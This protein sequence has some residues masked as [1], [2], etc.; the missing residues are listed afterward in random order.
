MWLRN[1]VFLGLLL[2]G[3][4]SLAA[5]LFPTPT[6]PRV[7]HFNS[8]EQQP[9]DFRSVVERVDAS[10]Q[11]QWEELKLQPAERT[12]DL[13]VAQRLSL[14]LMGTIPS[15]QEI[16]E[17]EKRPAEERIEWW[18]AGIFQDRRY[19]DYVAERLARAFVGTE[20][21]PF[22][23]YRRRRFVSW[24][25]D[26]LAVNRGYDAIVRE[27]IADDGLWTDQPATNFITVTIQNDR[28]PDPERLAGRVA[29]AFLGIRIDCA[30]CHNHPFEKWKQSDFQGLAAYFGQ[31][32]N[33]FSGIKDAAG[34]F[35]VENRKTGEHET[36]SPHVPFLP[37]LLPAQGGRRQQ[38]AAWVTDKRNPYFARVTV[39][40]TWALLFGRPLVD[41]VD[42][43]PASGD[44]P[45]ALEVLAADFAEHDFDL[46]RL[47]R[48]IAATA[49]FHLDSRKIPELTQEESEVYEREFAQFPLTRLR[50]EQVV[51]KLLQASS[52]ETVNRET[53]ILTRMFAYLRDR[54]FVQRYGD[55]GED[56]FTPRCATIPQL[57]LTMNGTLVHE[58]TRESLF[59]AATRIGMMAPDDGSAVEIAYLAALTRPPTPFEASYFTDRLA[60]TRG[61]ERARRMEDLYWTLVNSTEF[62]W[63]H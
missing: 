1:V 51:G 42:N 37:D 15:V 50:P 9:A 34:E 25:G 38:L 41:P 61:P 11:K 30:Q 59:G 27:L 23:V 16:R 36:I 10:F 56:E 24:L 22:I 12:D 47:I 55:P 52:L 17:F 35:S 18:L 31:V 26:Q 2:A 6:P 62:S 46:Q 21:G 48:L 20:D 49:P 13:H 19:A 5:A 33:S 53:H 39:N 60:G 8:A 4:G 45:A 29:R 44:L 43:L 40:R 28:G 58:R 7:L 32:K 3:V 63:N 57:L 54:E 14:A